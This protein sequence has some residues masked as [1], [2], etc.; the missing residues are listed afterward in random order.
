VNAPAAVLSSDRWRRLVP[1]AFIT[2]SFAY[3]DRSNYSIGAA[4]GL[5]DRLH[6]TSTQSGLLGGLFFIGY[7][8]FQVPAGDFAERRSVK[9]LMFWSLSA[10]GVLASLQGVI[11]TYWLLLVDRFA[12]GVVEAVV[13]P[14][15]VVVHQP[16]TRPCQHVPHPRQPD[17][18]A[19]DVSRLRLSRPRRGLPMD[20]HHRGAAGDRVGVPVPT[21]GGRPAG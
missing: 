1:I 21:V 17:H 7:F 11:T 3:L 2:Y 10:W 4:G 19:V 9:A 16:R 5:T 12:L 13:L 14:G 15:M 20:V 6:I 8:L 18:A